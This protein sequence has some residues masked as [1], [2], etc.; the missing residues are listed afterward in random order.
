[1]YYWFHRA[2]VLNN[3]SKV[4]ITP[5]L[6]NSDVIENTF[7]QQRSTYHGA[8]ANPNAIQ[9]RK[10]LNSIV[11]RQIT[12]S[13]KANAGKSRAAAMPYNMPYIICSF[14]KPVASTRRS[15]PNSYG[16]IKVLRL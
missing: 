8:N 2:L 14:R 6:V 5:G 11:L 3:G 10:A 4:Y 15:K 12:V 9:Y 13:Q 1:M 7:H 16:K